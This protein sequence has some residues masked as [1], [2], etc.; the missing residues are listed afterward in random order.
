GE[1]HFAKIFPEGSYTLTVRDATSGGLARAQLFLRTGVNA[2]HDFRLKGKGTVLVRVVEGSD[3]PVSNAFVRVTETEF[4]GGVHESAIEA[5]NQG[6][7]S[8]EGVFEGSISVDVSDSF[9]RGGR[10]SSVVG[11]PGAR[12][13]VKVRLTATGTV[14]GHF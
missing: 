8:L 14:R 10:A 5:A 6:V 9:A 13:E 2:T 7:A 12:V 11:Y 4:P 1:Y 3:Q